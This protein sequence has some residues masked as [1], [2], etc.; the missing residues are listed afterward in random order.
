MAEY[1]KFTFAD[2]SLTKICKEIINDRV[3]NSSLIKIVGSPYIVDGVATNFS[4]SDYLYQDSLSLPSDEITISIKGVFASGSNSKQCAW[5]LIG[6]DVYPIILYASETSI[7]L[8]YRTETICKL[9][10]LILNSN[11]AISIKVRIDSTNCEI[12]IF[13]GDT[14]YNIVEPLRYYLTLNKYTKVQIG[15]FEDSQWA[16]NIYIAPFS[17]S[18]KNNIIYTPSDGPYFNLSKILISD[19]EYKLTDNTKPVTHHIYELG[20][21]EITR[22]GSTLLI[23]SLI[24][25]DT[26]LNIREIGLYDTSGE[27]PVLFSVADN[28]SIN[29]TEGLPYDLIFTL[30][31]SLSI[32][33]I[34]GFP[35]TGSFLVKDPGYI[36]LFKFN[37][38]ERTL[39]YV[40]T[41]LERIIDKNALEIGYNRP[42]V[43][44]KL[45]Q[46]ISNMEHCY[47]TIQSYA[48]MKDK[49]FYKSSREFDP[50]RV[51]VE[52]GI[53]INNDTASNFNI[54]NYLYSDNLRDYSE[55]WEASFSF[56]T[57]EGSNSSGTVGCLTSP[58]VNQPLEVFLENGFCKASIGRQEVL[59]IGIQGYNSPFYYKRSPLGDTQIGDTSYACWN[60]TSDTRNFLID[61]SSQGELVSDSNIPFTDISDH[62]EWT[63]IPSLDTSLNWSI[64]FTFSMSSVTGTHYLLDSQGTNN[65]FEL[66][67]EDSKLKF[68]A[69]KESDPTQSVFGTL[70]MSQS[71]LPDVQYSLQFGY[72][73]Y[74]YF[75]NLISDQ[76]EVPE[77]AET[78]SSEIMNWG[79]PMC[80]GCSYNASSG[81]YANPMG[82]TID[83]FSFQI[84]SNYEVIWRAATSL[85]SLYTTTSS[86]V[87]TDTL[88]NSLGLGMEQLSVINMDAQKIYEGNLFEILP[89]QKYVL[90]VNSIYDFENDKYIFTFY[91]SVAG[92]IFT[93]IHTE[94]SNLPSNN[95]SSIYIGA[96]PTYHNLKVSNVTRPVNCSIPLFDWY[97]VKGSLEW[98]MYK[99]IISD[100]IL[101]QFFNIPKLSIK[102]FKVK[103]INNTGADIEIFGDTFESNGDLISFNNE[104]G[105]TLLMKVSLVDMED[106]VLLVKRSPYDDLNFIL[107]LQD[108]KISFLLYSEEGVVEL[109]KEL[110]VT[111]YD[112]YER[113]PILITVIFNGN[114]VSPK[115]EM[116]K[117]NELISTYEGSIGEFITVENPKL[118]NYMDEGTENPKIYVSDIILIEGVITQKD[119]YY[120]N[121]L[122][123][124]NY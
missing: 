107:K 29:K 42:Q 37:S 71:I 111:E 120:I 93:A 15:A 26:Y 108:Q 47:N 73:G 49:F 114:F 41:N 88:F 116:Y 13:Q 52:G 99:D 55:T 44:Y 76:V 27:N 101:T 21:N 68:R 24:D 69:Y 2:S 92:S 56:E 106:K 81:N 104:N 62:R 121:N 28:L 59:E 19:G 35:D 79:D 25:A 91:K 6:N 46:D 96:H 3:Y 95:F 12:S 66:F 5:A 83:L 43:F 84:S 34:V 31:L 14:L 100:N 122:L 103:D 61:I 16:G 58:C 124:T 60:T 51:A 39:L 17:I 7:T 80:I 85:D 87:S 48:K 82:G 54:S 94:E 45:Q 22:S 33:N 115:F 23:E 32:V 89:G 70:E 110:D 105:I 113:T 11:N 10:G 50:S 118:Y 1:S 109:S 78:P 4:S 112:A 123:D 8:S 40:L 20:V 38:I 72:S 90:R 86:P 65:T 67:I 9:S 30:D 97:L 102:N 64:S 63:K 18:G 119:L 77:K 98:Y 53:E 57:N 74:V 75:M 117:N 36:S